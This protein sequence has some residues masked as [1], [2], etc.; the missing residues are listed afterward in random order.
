[1]NASAERVR[2]TASLASTDVIAGTPMS[3]TV[4]V[5]LPVARSTPANTRAT[6]PPADGGPSPS[7]AARTLEYW[8]G[9]AIERK[10]KPNRVQMNGGAVSSFFY[11]RRFFACLL[12]TRVLVAIVPVQ[13]LAGLR[14]VDGAATAR[15][16]LHGLVDG[17]HRGRRPAW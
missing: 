16:A 4:V 14:A 11:C 13:A 2:N 17:A 3:N 8:Y 5:A 12:V 6:L 7:S 9:E 1:M 15:A 10:G